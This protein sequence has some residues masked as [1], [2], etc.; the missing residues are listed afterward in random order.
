[1]PAPRKFLV[2]S[3]SLPLS[4]G[5]G[6]NLS[7]YVGIL[8]GLL[9][10]MLLLLWM[11]LRQLSNSVGKSVLQPARSFRQPRFEHRFQHVLWNKEG[12]NFAKTLPGLRLSGLLEC[13]FADSCKK[14]TLRNDLLWTQVPIFSHNKIKSCHGLVRRNY[15]PFFKAI[16]MFLLYYFAQKQGV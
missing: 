9:M 14:M 6:W 4:L 10:L 12:D 3:T 7:L 8:L 13:A 16:F 2:A 11:L 1:M 5:W 15:C